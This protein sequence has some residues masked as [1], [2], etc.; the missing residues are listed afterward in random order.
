MKKLTSAL[1]LLVFLVSC[2]AAPAQLPT[3]T[4]TRVPTETSAPTATESPVPPTATL[5]PTATLTPTV[6]LTPTPSYPAN[7]YGPTNFPDNVDP[8]TGL[9]VSDPALLNRRPMTIK[10]ENLP[11][12]DRPQ[13]GVSLA[14]IVYE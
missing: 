12:D 2:T 13:W 11:R 6:T 14:D 3:A 9:V 4:P 1:L 8:L 10:I 5:R 7:G